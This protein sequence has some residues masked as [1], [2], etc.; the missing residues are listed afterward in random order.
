MSGLAEGA[1][2]NHGG[3]DLLR[4]A[5]QAMM[6]NDSGAP[7]DTVDDVVAQGEWCPRITSPSGAGWPSSSVGSA[8]TRV[9]HSPSLS[10]ETAFE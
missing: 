3:F 1:H 10:S 5:T 9:S 6:S 4:R 8:G 2:A 7:N